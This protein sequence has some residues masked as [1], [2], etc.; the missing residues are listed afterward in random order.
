MDAPLFYAPPEAVDGDHIELPKSESHHAISVMR[1]KRG[2]IVIVINGLGQACRGEIEQIGRGKNVLVRVHARLRNFGEPIVRVTLAAGLSVGSKQDSIV[3]KATELGI[4]RFVPI[5]SERS[6]VKL[7]DPKR[8]TSKIRRLE[9]VALAAVKQCRRS[10]CPEIAD[11]ISF[12]SFLKETEPSDTHLLFH[13]SETAE[14][15]QKY[16]PDDN[17]SRVT[18][19]LGPEAG[20]SD[21][22]VAAA[23]AAGY[24]IVSLGSRILRSETAAPVACALVMAHLGELR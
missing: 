18:L 4:K 19:L 14:S 9:K 22:E 12:E 8:A 13:P 2:D 20:F 7:E 21:D 3:Q 10:Y 16:L 11:P 6:R 23:K 1:L 17:V 15:L 24:A 5:L